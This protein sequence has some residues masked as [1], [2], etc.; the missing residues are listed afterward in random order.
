[1]IRRLCIVA[2]LALAGGL[3][4]AGCGLAPRAVGS[5][6]VSVTVTKS[7]GTQQVGQVSKPRVNGSENVLG[8]LEGAFP[9]TSKTAAGSVDSIDGLRAGVSDTSWFYYVNGVQ[10]ATTPSSTSVH[11]GDHIW[12]DLHDFSATRSIPAV[13]GS[14][15]EPFTNGID[16]KRYTVTV[17]C[18]SDVGAA[19]KR[20]TAALDSLHIPAAPQ[21]LGTGSGPD[22][23][24]VVVGTWS[25]IRSEVAAELVAYGP[26]AS[27]VFAR[28][29]GAGDGTLE[30]LDASGRVVRTLGAGAGLIA[31]TADSQSVPTWMVTGTDPAGVTAAADAL[32]PQGL[33]NHFAVAVDGPTVIPVPVQ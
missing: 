17:E 24:G 1:M 31:A 32:T 27:G 29:G 13:V 12:W 22:T 19:C 25:Q 33:R 15:P 21:L 10:A 20:V 5:P 3:V 30:L 4:C 11:S 6:G 16:G 26:G 23:L 14:Y 28:F 7:F 9:S 2:V 8:L 18:G